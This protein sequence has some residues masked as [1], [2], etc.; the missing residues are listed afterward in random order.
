MCLPHYQR[1]TFVRLRGSTVLV[2]FTIRK[3]AKSLPTDFRQKM[4]EESFNVL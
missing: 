1:F 2:D 3:C 4:R